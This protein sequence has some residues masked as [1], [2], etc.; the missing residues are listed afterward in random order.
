MKGSILLGLCLTLFVIAPT[1]A[2]DEWTLMVY[3]CCDNDLN[4][5]ALADIDEM[6]SINNTND[7][8]NIIVQIDGYWMELL[9]LELTMA[10][11]V[12]MTIRI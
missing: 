10:V 6:E 5:D 11:T 2:E 9:R 4:D 1:V 3:I 12:I 8:I 7:T